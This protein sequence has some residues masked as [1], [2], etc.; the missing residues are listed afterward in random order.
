[1]LLVTGPESFLEGLHCLMGASRAGWYPVD[2]VD[3]IHLYVGVKGHP[4]HDLV[5][6]AESQGLLGRHQ[7]WGGGWVSPWNGCWLLL[8]GDGEEGGGL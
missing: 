8:C 3:L 7:V 6:E 5:D 4:G 2:A 1:M